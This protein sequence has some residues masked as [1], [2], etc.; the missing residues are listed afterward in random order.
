MDSLKHAAAFTLALFGFAASNAQADD[1]CHAL[2]TPYIANYYGSYK[3]WRIDLQQELAKTATQTPDGNSAWT[4][5]IKVD[6]FLGSIQEQTSYWLTPQGN[7]ISHE[8]GYKRN[9]FVNRFEQHMVFDW[10]ARLAKT[11]GDKSGQANLQG[12]E[13]DN[14]NYQLMLRCQLQQGKH[15]FSFRV[16]DRNKV[17]PLDFRII[18]EERLDTKFGQLDTVVVKRIREN[19]NRVTTIWFAKDLDYMMVKLLQEEKK[20]TQAYLLYIDDLKPLDKFRVAAH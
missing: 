6:N 3:G 2:T 8:Y 15:E 5:S 19:P 16:V 12:N 4:M 1:I 17:D 7:I 14:L 13:L 20:D 11:T 9:V 18:G 10:K